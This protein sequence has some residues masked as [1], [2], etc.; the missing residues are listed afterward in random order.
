MD[1]DD[2]N[3]SI[4]VVYGTFCFAV[5]LASIAGFVIH[6]LEGAAIA[7]VGMALAFAFGCFCFY[8]Y[9]KYIQ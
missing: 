7:G 1:D 2:Y 5:G 9:D 4:V 3:G 8:F 6:G